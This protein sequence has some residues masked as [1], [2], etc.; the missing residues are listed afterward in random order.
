M[1]KEPVRVTAYLILPDF[2]LDDYPNYLGFCGRLG[3]NRRKLHK[4]KAYVVWLHNH[5][6][7]KN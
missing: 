4:I 3:V 7:V 6:V 2:G 1:N 5:T